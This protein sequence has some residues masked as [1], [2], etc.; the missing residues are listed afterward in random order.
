MWI[1][2]I[3]EETDFEKEWIDAEDSDELRDIII[4]SWKKRKIY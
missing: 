1:A 3:A 2:Q 4:S